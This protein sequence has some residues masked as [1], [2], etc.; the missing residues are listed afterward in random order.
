MNE[1]KVI[2]YGD[3]DSGSVFFAPRQSTGLILGCFVTMRLV[4]CRFENP[5]LLKDVKAASI[6]SHKL[7]TEFQASLFT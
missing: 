6:N 1:V 2:V 3:T 7:E 4:K 5:I